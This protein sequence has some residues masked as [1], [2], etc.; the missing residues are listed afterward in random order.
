MKPFSRSDRVGGLIK[1]VL[2]E[3]LH[4]QISDPR[5]EGAT[6]T[7]VQVSRDLRLAKIYFCTPA[8]EA[9]RQDALDA[10]ERARGF[11]KR[12]LAQRMTLRYMPDLRFYYDGSIDY[13]ARIEQLLKAVKENDPDHH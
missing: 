2:A 12:E 3:L 10:F 5:L 7:G 9:T 11:V 8:G 4:K 6:I 13:A 1:Q